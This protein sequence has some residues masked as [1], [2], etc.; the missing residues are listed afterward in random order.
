MRFNAGSEVRDGRE[1]LPPYPTGVRSAQSREPL[2]IPFDVEARLRYIGASPEPTALPTVTDGHHRQKAGKPRRTVRY[3]GAFLHLSAE[4]SSVGGWTRPGR[5]RIHAPC[6]F[7][8]Y[9]QGAPMRPTGSYLP[10]TAGSPRG[11][12]ENGRQYGLPIYRR[13]AA[14]P[15]RPVGQCDS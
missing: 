7:S 6:R 3:L 14:S 2:Y 15:V 4:N 13:R 9:T 12:E 5:F 8:A 10:A 11:W 1:N